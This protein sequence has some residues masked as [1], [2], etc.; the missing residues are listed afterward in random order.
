MV[1]PAAVANSQQEAEEG[2]TC[3]HVF[4]AVMVALIVAAPMLFVT[5][6]LIAAVGRYTD[7]GWGLLA[8]TVAVFIATSLISRGHSDNSRGHL[9]SKDR[10]VSHTNNFSFA[11]SFCCVGGAMLLLLDK[12]TGLGPEGEEGSEIEWSAG[13]EIVVTLLLIL[14]I[15]YT[16][17]ARMSL[18]ILSTAYN[19][20][21]PVVRQIIGA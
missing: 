10:V 9:L 3:D 8:S 4:N 20:D 15:Y 7:F 12:I 2:V 17:I 21:D 19:K 18:M 1:M 11:A 6:V 13:E 14:S 16:M 5:G